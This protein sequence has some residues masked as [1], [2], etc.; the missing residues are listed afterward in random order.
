[1]RRFVTVSWLGS[2][3]WNVSKKDCA[4]ERQSYG[5]T[6]GD[7]FF[8][9]LVALWS[10]MEWTR[11]TVF[12]FCWWMATGSD[13]PEPEPHLMILSV[14]FAVFP[15]CVWTRYPEA[16]SIWGKKCLTH[17]TAYSWKRFRHT[18]KY[19]IVRLL[20]KSYFNQRFFMEWLIDLSFHLNQCLFIN[21]FSFSY[22][23][24]L[25]LISFLATFQPGIYRCYIF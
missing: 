8:W 23:L 1:M 20:N 7:T 21:T 16:R 14:S 9:V 12:C 17:V 3:P 11:Y 2:S 13:L 4:R 5:H 25:L 18:Q 15:A 24:F 10:F 6:E 19:S 22:F